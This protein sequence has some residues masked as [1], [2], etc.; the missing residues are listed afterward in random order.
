MKA[1]I[2]TIALF[3]VA[4]LSAQ[5]ATGTKYNADGSVHSTCV[6]EGDHVWVTE[7]YADGT[8]K[9]KGSYYR[10]LPD[11]PWE[12][13]DESGELVVRGYFRQGKRDGRWQFFKT[14]DG[15][16]MELYYETGLMV[17][18]ERYNAGGEVVEKR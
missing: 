12:R 8:I 3:A 4:S 15:G 7:Y 16:Q 5:D 10:T 11:G 17:S 13:F 18:G 14:A 2:L 1:I 6:I 9:E